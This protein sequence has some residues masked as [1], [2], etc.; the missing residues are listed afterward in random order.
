M[1]HKIREYEWDEKTRTVTSPTSHSELSKVTEFKNQDWAKIL[2]QA[3]NSAPTKKF[4]DPNAAFPFQDEFSVGTIHGANM[5]SPFNNQGVETGTV[6]EIINNDNGVSV[7]TSKSQDL[8]ERKRSTSAIGR[9][10]ASGVNSCA[11][12]PTPDATP[13]GANGTAPVAAVGSQIPACT[14]NNGRVNGGPVGK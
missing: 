10:A 14:G 12:G 1:L 9:R 6:V 8:N 5:T 4:V 13:A 11:S 3:D 7:L 2:A